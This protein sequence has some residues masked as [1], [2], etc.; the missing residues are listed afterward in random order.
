[1]WQCQAEN[2]SCA[3]HWAVA[4]P[5]RSSST[6]KKD[7]LDKFRLE[8]LIMTDEGALNQVLKMT[9]V[10]PWQILHPL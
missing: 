3:I 1:M 10:F 2:R 8:S 7:E 6:L 5:C 9:G 4:E